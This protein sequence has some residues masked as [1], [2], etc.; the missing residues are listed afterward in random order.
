MCVGLCQ[1]F[2]GGSWGPYRMNLTVFLRAGSNKG[3]MIRPGK[4]STVRQ[5]S[6]FLTTDSAGVQCTDGGS[7]VVHTTTAM[8]VT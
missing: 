8:T 1:W 4:C 7:L 6:K 5:G 3:G 2:F